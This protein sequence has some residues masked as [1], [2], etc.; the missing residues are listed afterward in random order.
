MTQKTPSI[1]SVIRK[2]DTTLVSANS[3]SFATFDQWMDVQLDLLVAQWIHTAAP[4]ASRVE[5]NQ[6]RL[7]R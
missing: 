4:N 3:E 5:R 6:R 2:Q 1:L 7:G